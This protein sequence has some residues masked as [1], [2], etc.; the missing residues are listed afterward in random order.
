MAER[1]NRPKL[2]KGG[3]FDPSV[4]ADRLDALRELA[5]VAPKDVATAV[6]PSQTPEN[7]ARS[8]YK[9]VTQKKTP[10]S[11][12]EIKAVVDYLLAA[13]NRTGALDARVLPGF[14]FVDLWVAV[15]IERGDYER[16]PG[17]PHKV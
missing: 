3:R 16:P 10:F 7:A 4:T 9:R 5:G 15:G 17:G 2:R 12:A 14:P 6:W 13:A 1:R 11:L 8:W